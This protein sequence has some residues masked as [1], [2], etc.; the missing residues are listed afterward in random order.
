MIRPL[1]NCQSLTIR[2]INQ[3]CTLVEFISINI[4]FNHSINS[5][6][7]YESQRGIQGVRLSDITN[8]HCIYVVT[9]TGLNTELG[10]IAEELTNEKD[11]PTPLQRKIEEISNRLTQI[12]L[13]I[14]AFVFI[15]NSFEFF[16]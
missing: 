8:G 4:F 2:R 11:V 5:S 14:I 7:L 12:V 3:I 1:T 16:E 13:V 10:K 9:D 15:Y 6:Y